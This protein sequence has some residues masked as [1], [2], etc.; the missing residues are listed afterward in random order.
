MPI[1]DKDLGKY[2]RPGIFIEEINNSIIELPVQDVL[3]NLVPG[4]SKKGPVNSPTYI[5]NKTDFTKIFGDIDRG[6]ERKGSYFHRTCLKMLESGPIWALNLLVTDDSRDKLNWK[7]ISVSSSFENNVTQLM[8]YT[9]LFNRQDFWKRDDESFL[10]YVNSVSTDYNRLLHLTNMGDKTITTFIY[11][12]NVAGFNVTAEQWYGGV[13]KIPSYINA[14]DWIS[15]YMVSILI[16]EGDWTDYDALSVDSTWSK[17]FDNTGLIKTK[18]Q[19]FVNEKNVT[20][21]D[22]KDASLIPYFKDIDGR[23]LYIKNLI[24]NNTDRTGLFCA[25]YED[26]LLDSDYPTDKVD[27]IGNGLVNNEKNNINF[28]SYSDTIIESKTYSEQKLDDYNNVF[29]NYSTN[30]EDNFNSLATDY[31]D[32]TCT[33]GYIHNTNIGV[34]G[35]TLVGVYDVVLSTGK[36]WIEIALDDSHQPQGIPVPHRQLQINDIIYFNKSFSIIQANTPYYLVEGTQSGVYGGYNMWTIS[37]TKGGVPLTID[38]GVLSGVYLQ[39]GELNL[40][41]T[42][43]SA[44]FNIDGVSYTFNSANTNITFEPLEFSTIGTTYE[45]YDVLYL[46]KGDNGIVN[47]LKGVQSDNSSASKPAFNLD[48]TDY[49]I[50]GYAHL[51]I[52]NGV[53]PGTGSTNNFLNVDYYPVSLDSTGYVPLTNI[54]ATGVTMGGSNYVQL[55]FGYTSGTTDNTNYNKLRYRTAYDE[56]EAY[57]DNL[58]G[59]IINK[60]NGEKYQITSITA[61]DYSST[62]NAILRINVGLNTPSDYFDTTNTYKF[63]LYYVD[64][65][66][67]IKTSADR[68]L[69]SNKIVEDLVGSGQTNNAGVI[70]KYSDIYLDYYNG[71]IN[72]WDYVYMSNNTSSTKIYMKMWTENEDSLYVDFVSDTIGVS[73]EPITDWTT[74]YNSELIIWSNESNYKQTV[75]IESFDIT[76]YPNLVYEIKIDKTRYSEIKKGDFIEAYYNETDYEQGGSKYGQTPKKLTRVISTT[77]DSTN[78]NLK[79]IKCDSPIK[80][81][82][83]SRVG[84]TGYDYQTTRYL[85]VDTYVDTYKG[86]SLVPFTIHADSLPNNTETRLNTILNLI[87]KSTNLSKGLANKNKI[88][89]RY[90][91][92]SFGLGLTS[93]SK[94]QYADLCGMKL[95]CLAFINMP[96]VKYLKKS[97][98]PSF[99]NDD[100][101]VN[102]EY[103]KNGGDETKSPS[104]LYTFADG[105]GSTCVAYFFPYVV[106]DDNGVPKD[107][108]PASYAAT[109]YM[110]KFITTQAGIEPFTVCAGITTGRIT[111]IA[112]TEMDFT[113]TD[114]ENLDAMGANAIVKKKDAGYCLDNEQTA[115][116]FP[117]SS[118]SLIHSREVLIE[119]E[120]AIYDMLLRYQWRVNTPEVRSEIKL[121]ADKILKD[122]KNRDAIYDFTTVMNE[123]N[124]TNYIIDLQMGVLDIALELVKNFKIMVNNI[125]ILKK[126][127]IESSGFSVQ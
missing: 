114:L 75:E 101:T 14:K 86:I 28:L 95:N 50:L 107:V 66:F 89:W 123:T 80:V 74:S 60:I 81:T 97:S 49:I 6:L 93:R 72:A 76:K 61:Y 84:S 30:L 8:P 19:D 21:L 73:P 62:S 38:T 118:L 100:Y 125:T 27:V 70:G 45:R 105:I 85:T 2:K 29:G 65:E 43:T 58:Q 116:V 11:K 103:L 113:D 94:Q 99:I 17:Y 122:F 77:L 112:E 41:G 10:D 31:R 109:T 37:T 22:Y 82:R 39:K 55:T 16:V 110:N 54:A 23:D 59:V 104:F 44:Y 9:R 25:Y 7:S 20:I 12:S 52:T 79:V 117:Y 120:N 40:G 18:I 63:L 98:N 127:T 108:P 42:I 15:D 71:I 36:T 3:I 111:N 5:T 96:S 83:Y 47:I 92:D 67:V 24:N 126:G 78:S 69:T 13:T 87:D 64:K 68:L 32:A 91:I 106:V 121:K 35:S 119:V 33:N 4:F 57:L 102:T 90:L 56:L 124:N 34:S 48:P 1:Q 51:Y 26:S 88:S 46:S 115:Q 53:T